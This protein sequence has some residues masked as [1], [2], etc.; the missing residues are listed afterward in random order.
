MND[1]FRKDLEKKSIVNL[2]LRSYGRTEENHE[3]PQDSRYS[4]QDLNSAPPESG[5]AI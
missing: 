5:V 1:Q 4:D 3:K 2:N